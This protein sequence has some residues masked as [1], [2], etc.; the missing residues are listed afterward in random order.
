MRNCTATLFLALVA[1][2][3]AQPAGPVVEYRSA[4]Q[5]ALLTCSASL[6][7]HLLQE[8]LGPRDEHGDYRACV[9]REKAET[10]RQLDVAMRTLKRTAAREALKTY[11]VAFATAMDGIDP[12]INERKVDYERR[13]LELKGSVAQAWARF[14]LEQ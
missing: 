14:E 6:R 3:H 1:A 10:R 11:H 8:R 4:T 7:L 12:G 5:Y 9:M 13:Q 2:V